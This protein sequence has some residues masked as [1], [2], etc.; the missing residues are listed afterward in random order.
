MKQH[1][2]ALACSATKRMDGELMPALDRYNGVMWQTLRAALSE[3]SDEVKQTVDIWFLSARYGFHLASMP[4]SY[5]EEL[6]TPKRAGE[7]LSLPTSNHIAFS[8]AVRQA[9][10]VMFAGGSLY[11][12]TMKKA[13]GA[14]IGAAETDGAGI[15]FHRQQLREWLHSL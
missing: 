14:Q 2:L 5:Y 9:T 15:G 12:E 3:L 11:R 10:K 13:A 8:G 4:I 6:M 1:I 7:L